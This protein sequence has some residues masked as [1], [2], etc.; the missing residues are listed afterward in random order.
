VFKFEKLTVWHRA[1]AFAEMIYGK[2][3][4][5][6]NEERFGLTAQIRR[7]AVSVSSNIAEGSARPDQDFAR[8]VGIAS[9]SLYEV[10]TQAMIA[11][12]LRYLSEPDY[13]EIYQ[14]AEEISRMLSG[15]RDSLN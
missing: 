12:N 3:V 4:D 6:P 9:G 13:A 8:F 7:A 1:A 14:A 2:S 10:I 5:F 11:R 15:L